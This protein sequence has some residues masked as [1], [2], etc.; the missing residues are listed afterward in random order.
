[1]NT[2]GKTIL[3]VEDDARL[4][5][6]IKIGLENE[7][8]EV[9]EAENGLDG[10]NLF[11]RYDPCFVITDLIMPGLS[12][13]ELTR[14][15][16]EHAKSDVPIIM[17][18]AKA[19]EADRIRGLKLGA[20]DYITKPFSLPELIVRVETVLRRTEHR[21]SKISYRGITLKPLKNEAKYEGQ[22]IALTRHEFKLMYYLMRHPNQVLSREQILKELYP[23]DEKTVVLRTVD[24]HIGKLRDKLNSATA[25]GGMIETIRGIGYRFHAF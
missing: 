7:G 8:Y 3:I 2:L 23:H 4:R 6:L 1:M 20:D 18:S 17:L 19:D 12:G 16:R 9:W 10:R 5:Q 25:D 24:V 15:I 11:D 13:E 22:R 21:C 14:W